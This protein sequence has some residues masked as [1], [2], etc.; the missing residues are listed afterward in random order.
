MKHLLRLAYIPVLT[1]LS[2]CASLYFPPPPHAPLLTHQGEA[3][4][5]VST[6][7]QNNFALQGAYAITN[8]LGVAGTFSSLHRSKSR[9]T[10]NLDF[11]ELSVGYFTRLSD[12]RVLEVYVGAGGGATE[13]IER[14]AEKITTRT[15]DGSLSKVFA[16]VNY[17]RKK[18]DNLRLFSHDFPLTYGAALRMS[19]MQLNN[20]RINGE[21]AP[22]ENNLFFEP[23][24]FTR[25]QIAGP[26]QLQ[27]LSGQIF[28]FRNN[29]YLK[30]ANSVFQVGIIVNIGEGF[31]TQ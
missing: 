9:K 19:Y 11:G 4:G 16:Q 14:N 18:R 22:G 31:L 26:V 23:I 10:E 13:R 24:T 29:K 2:S 12:K 25:T 28:G 6:N 3:Y 30:A 1:G 21:V 20:F 17:A 8:H 15:L 7:L 27:F 5:S